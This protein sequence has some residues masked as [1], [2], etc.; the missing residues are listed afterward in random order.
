M[1]GKFMARGAGNQ[2][3]LVVDPG[4]P[5]LGDESVGR[6]EVRERFFPEGFDGGGH[7]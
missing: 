1:L 7:L 6:W 4:V 5:T 3:R 2:L